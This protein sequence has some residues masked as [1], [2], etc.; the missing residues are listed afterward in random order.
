MT[1]LMDIQ[2][3]IGKLQRQA[4][5]IKRK[6]FER[7]VQDII[8]K[9]EAFGITEKDLFPGRG[10]KLKTKGVKGRKPAA[11]GS[12]SAG[13][14]VAPKFRGPNGEAWSGR[15]LTP[16]WLAALESQGNSRD[17]FAIKP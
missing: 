13:T 15:G 14:K 8:A 16:K 5:E 2:N 7:T 4:E 12:A 6:D 11:K 9:I 1:N 3:Q 17:D 10:G